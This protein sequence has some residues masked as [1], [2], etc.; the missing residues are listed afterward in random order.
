MAAETHLLDLWIEIYETFFAL[1]HEACEGSANWFPLW[2][3]GKFYATHCDFAFNLSP[4]DFAK[5]FVPTIAKQCRYL[6]HS[7]HHLDGEGNFCHVEALCEVERLG[8]IQV[9]PGPGKPGPLSYLPM[10]KRIQAKGKNLHL[11]LNAGEVETALGELSAC[12]LFIHTACA[13]EG[14]ARDLIKKCEHWSHDRTV[15]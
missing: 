6:D 4:P 13:T 2:S 8:G 15:I 1:Y 5:V 3:P 14:E 9:L 10:L 12:G 11:G 7:I